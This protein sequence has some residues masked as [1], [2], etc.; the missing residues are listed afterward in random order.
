MRTIRVELG[1]NSYEILIGAGLL[2]QAGRRLREHGFAGKLV[3]ITDP[4]VDRLHGESL[5]K[6]LA[7]D[8]TVTTLLVPEGEAQKSLE[9]ASRLYQ[10][11]TDA[12]AERNTPILAL[13]GGVIGDL[14]GFV[15]ATYQ[16]GVPLIQLPTT[17]LAQVD[18]SIGG[19]VAVDH[20]QLKNQV[21][22]F[23]QPKL[24]VADITTLKTLPP[25][26]FANG[27]AEVIKSAAI[28]NRTI[29]AFLEDNLDR[30]K[31]LDDA[32]LEETVFQTAKIKAGVVEKDE[33]DT[34][35]RNI[36]NY[37]HTIGHAVEAVSGFTM[38]HGQAVAIGMVAAAR[39]SRK[40]GMLTES[41]VSRLKD[42]IE[43][44]GLPSSL[45]DISIS[46]IIESMQHDKK[47][48][49]SRIRFILLRSLGD[50]F[51]TDEVSPALVEQVLNE[52]T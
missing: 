11:L 45:P 2:G 16:R 33:T 1:R 9:T 29:F 24:V 10:E 51:V 36:L 21:G 7:K 18:S 3:I 5:K 30:I 14:A 15:A 19:K 13:G 40:M 27:L 22:A 47:V 17:L 32:A 43:K 46:R 12:R 37:G 20:G 42:L 44:A 41:E 26:E 38:K 48:Q 50:A 31:S 34:G 35:L 4:T 8:F 25:D 23:Y 39:I 6:G 49:H 52:T 28:R